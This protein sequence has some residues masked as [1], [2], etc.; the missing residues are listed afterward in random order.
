[1]GELLIHSML[2]TAQDRIK[3]TILREIKTE[4]LLVFIHTTLEQYFLDVEAK[5]IN[6]ALGSE[7]DNAI[8]QEVLKRLLGNLQKHVVNSKYIRTLTH[9]AEQNIQA[10]LL[11]KKEASLVFYYDSIV[12]QMQN[13]LRNGDSW[14][15]AQLIL[16]LLSEW[17]LEEEKSVLLFPFLKEID[18]IMLLSKYDKVSLEAKKHNDSFQRDTIQEMYQLGNKLIQKLKTCKFKSNTQRKSKVRKK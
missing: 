7:E 13:S 17:I 11:L 1:M 10:R 15:P 5:R 16:C 6:F 4:A 2:V 9:L 12:K 8:L 3:P 18:Y 14:I